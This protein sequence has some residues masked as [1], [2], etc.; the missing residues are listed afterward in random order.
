MRLSAYSLTALE[1]RAHR[2]WTADHSVAR[3][4]AEAVEAADAQR[5]MPMKPRESNPAKPLPVAKP[6]ESPWET[7]ER[8][9]DE[10]EEPP[11]EGEVV[12]ERYD[13]P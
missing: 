8:L 6:D 11:D 7:Y 13:G 5:L 12:T 10:E 3:R 9:E 1:E 2:R 4:S